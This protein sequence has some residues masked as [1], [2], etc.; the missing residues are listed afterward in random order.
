MKPKPSHLIYICLFFLCI[1]QTTA[2]PIAFEKILPDTM[3][4][5]LRQLSGSKPA[6]IDGKL[7]NIPERANT[8]N[9]ANARAFLK[10]FY[11]QYGYAV[12]EHNYGAG[13]N[14]VAI[15]NGED[16]SIVVVGAHYDG[17][18]NIPAA[19][20][21]AAGCISVLNAAK[22][23]AKCSFKHTIHFLAFDQEELGWRGATAYVNKLDADGKLKKVI[24]MFNSEG[25]S[26]DSDN[27]GHF[28][29]NDRGGG[30]ITRNKILVDAIQA[31]ITK[32]SI[33][34]VPELERGTTFRVESDMKAFWDKNIPATVV[35]TANTDGGPCYHKPCDSVSSKMNFE[36]S[37]KMS[38]M[39]AG[40]T[41]ELAKLIGTSVVNSVNLFSKSTD[42][43]SISKNGFTVH[44]SIKKQVE[45]SVFSI[46]G[47]KVF[48]GMVSVNA[49]ISHKMLGLD[50]ANSLNII[51]MTDGNHH[52]NFTLP[53]QR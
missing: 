27:D 40:A 48:S 45:V 23:L 9:R 19:D 44:S 30:G 14:L 11:L 38:K 28:H 37:A 25:V 4:D 5:M 20:D 12:S 10:Q 7:V 52:A 2:E 21:N 15:K 18:S 43:I 8:T 50:N 33:A 29:L 49:L 6:L 47:R 42:M 31:A 22:A 41:A 17:V 46:T 24:A 26:F 39:T 35:T 16:D 1:A 32:Y 53:V 13:V 51:K 3:K 36:F 34:L